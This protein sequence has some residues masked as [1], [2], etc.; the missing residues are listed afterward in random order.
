[1]RPVFVLGTFFRRRFKVCFPVELV[2]L[3]EIVFGMGIGCFITRYSRNRHLFYHSTPIIEPIKVS[4]TVCR[5]VSTK[6]MITFLS[7]FFSD[8][9]QGKLCDFAPLPCVLRNDQKTV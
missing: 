1:M 7:F 8:E 4:K 6:G 2:V 9:D 5:I 3:L